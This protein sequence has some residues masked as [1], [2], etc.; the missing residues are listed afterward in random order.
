MLVLY[1]QQIGITEIKC[2]RV[3]WENLYSV[4]EGKIIR[5]RVECRAMYSNRKKKRYV[6]NNL[7]ISYF[8]FYLNQNRTL[9]SY[10]NLRI[11]IP[12]EKKKK[13]KD[14]K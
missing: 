6:R 4:Y 3:P 10:Y 13:R 12:T 7:L 5:L 2:T 11:S 1:V 8:L 14:V 9:S